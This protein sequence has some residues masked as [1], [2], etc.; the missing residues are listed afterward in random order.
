MSNALAMTFNVSTGSADLLG[1]RTL[2]T[3]DWLNVVVF[4]S[5]FTDA[6]AEP[7]ERPAGDDEHGGYWGDTFDTRSHGSLLWTLRR[8]KITNEIQLR[9][10]DICL[11]ALAWLVDAKKVRAIDV[12]TERLAANRLGI[13]VRV[14]RNDGTTT[15]IPQ[16]FVTNAV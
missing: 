3:D 4:T 11:Q 10:R 8:E 9:A 2:A 7:D 16:E 1:G 5:L 6:H 13:L 12:T 15:T 14:T